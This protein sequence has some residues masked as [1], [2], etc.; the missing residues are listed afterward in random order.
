MG[1]TIPMAK[2][3]KCDICE[4]NE[5]IYDTPTIHG[6]WAYV[7]KECL[8][9]NTTPDQLQIGNKLEVKKKAKPVD[10]VVQGI[11][12]STLQEVV[13]D[14]DRMVGCPECGCEQH[15]EPD[16][17]YE[18]TCDGCGVRVKCKSIM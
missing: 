14:G 3:P 17:T 4:K 12:K 8:S 1:R 11:E 2:L 5:A 7:C 18:F 16:A 15:V 10:R 9:E 6:P 13:M